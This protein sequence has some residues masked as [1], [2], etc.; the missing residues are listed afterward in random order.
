MSD[1]VDTVTRARG[2]TRTRARGWCITINNYTA[3]QHSTI[4]EFCKSKCEKWIIAKEIGESETPHI[5][6]Y[7]YF[8]NAISFNTIKSIIPT[9]HIEKAKGKPEENYNYCSKDGDFESNM[10]PEK[11]EQELDEE[12]IQEL[13]ADVIWHPWQQ[14]ILDLIESKPDTRSIHWYWESTGNIGKSFLAKYICLKYNAIIASGKRADVFNQVLTW[15]NK[16]GRRPK[17]IIIDVPR[18]GYDYIDYGGIESCKN[19]LLYS[20][21]YEGGVCKFYSPHVICFAN[22]K[23]HTHKMS[24]DRWQIREIG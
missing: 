20:G 7:M 22:E 15:I 10:S 23:P 11:S 14:Q 6:G 4:L 21:K 8:T 1:T 9:A 12:M 18:C 5:Q 16:Y 2:N 24:I 13:Y 17:V 19:G 3:Q